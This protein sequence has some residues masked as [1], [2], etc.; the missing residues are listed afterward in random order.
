MTVDAKPIFD[1]AAAY[2]IDERDKENGEAEI[3]VGETG[4]S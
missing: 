2:A 1:R 3:V 4:C